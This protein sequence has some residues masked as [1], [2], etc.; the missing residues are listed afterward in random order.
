[1]IE[2]ILL[3]TA[4]N[5]QVKIELFGVDQSYRYQQIKQR[6][7]DSMDSTGMRYTLTDIGDIDQFIAAGLASVPSIRVNE[8]ELFAIL[9]EDDPQQIVESVVN[10]I[11]TDNMPTVVIPIDFSPISRNAAM[12]AMRVADQYGLKVELLHV[13]HPVVDPHNAVVLDSDLGESHRKYLN[14]LAQELSGEHTAAISTKFEV[15]Y[16]LSAIV[17]ASKDPDVEL[18]VMGTLGA[19]NILDDVFGNISSSVAVQIDKPLLLI[20]P[21]TT[22]RQP[23]HIMVAFTQQL[24]NNGALDNLLNM[25]RPF[26]AHVDFVHI[27]NN[28]D[29]DFEAIRDRLTS[30]LINGNSAAFSFDIRQISATGKGVAHDIMATADEINPDWLTLVPKHR[31]FIQRLFHTSVTRQLCLHGHRPM[32][33]LHGE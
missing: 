21:D 23:E 19:T 22:Y 18:I 3:S 11:R 10:Y 27:G 14:D 1:M 24:I 6:L 20:P 13:Y 17:D 30:E 7:I 12:Y 28:N 8:K 33:I 26:G 25:N 15:G 31:N 5:E 4:M 29:D 32:M 2:A 9:E 16:P